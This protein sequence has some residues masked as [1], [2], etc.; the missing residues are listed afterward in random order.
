MLTPAI[1]DFWHGHDEADISRHS[2]T[3]LRECP[4]AD[5]QT[6]DGFQLPAG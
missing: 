4:P 1:H 2:Q 3:E 5:N 6:Q